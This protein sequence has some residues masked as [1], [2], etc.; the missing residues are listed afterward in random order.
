[1]LISEW[2]RYTQL[3]RHKVDYYKRMDSDTFG[4][5]QGSLIY[6]AIARYMQF[7]TTAA[8]VE[9]SFSFAALLMSASVPTAGARVCTGDVEEWFAQR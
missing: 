6:D 2:Q 1:M 3:E 9:R 5:A 7:P 8:L 4:L